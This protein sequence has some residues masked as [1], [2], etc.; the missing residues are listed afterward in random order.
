MRLHKGTS[1]SLRILWLYI[2]EEIP[3]WFVLRAPAGLLRVPARVDNL[4]AVAG[5][6]R[7][8]SCFIRFAGGAACFG[9]CYQDRSDSERKKRYVLVCERFCELLQ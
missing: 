4:V 5:P 9:Q 8:A 6:V 2:I 1:M 3:V 7:G